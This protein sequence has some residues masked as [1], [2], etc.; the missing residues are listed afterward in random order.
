MQGTFDITKSRINKNE[1][2]KD[3]DEIRSS[4]DSGCSVDSSGEM[5]QPKDQQKTKCSESQAK[6]DNAWSNCNGEPKKKNT[7]PRFTLTQSRNAQITT[8]SKTSSSNSQTE[9]TG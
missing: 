2:R 9:N 4:N 3:S 7:S 8:N 6:K 1:E 5:T